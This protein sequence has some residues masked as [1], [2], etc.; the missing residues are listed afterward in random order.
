MAKRFSCGVLGLT[1]WAAIAGGAAGQVVPGE[2][3]A[4]G[5]PAAAAP[6]PPAA[7]G[8]PVGL[9]QFSAFNGGGALL[10]RENGTYLHYGSGYKYTGQW[11]N[12]EAG[13]FA[14]RGADGGKDEWS[15]TLGP[16]GKTL[17]I[18]RASTGLTRRADRAAGDG[19]RLVQAEKTDPGFFLGVWRLTAQ[20]SLRTP[21][22]SLSVEKGGAATYTDAGGQVQAGRWAAADKFDGVVV[23]A[24]GTT[25]EVRQYWAD[26]TAVSVY[27]GR[28]WVTGDRSK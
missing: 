9:W 22:G 6:V 18:K 7:A 2:G 11:G 15:V 25:F 14:F 21:S 19:A 26:N 24:G 23:T 3:P 8:S 12:G 20:D 4:A 27:N 28:A 10:V 16:E 1:M 5:A 13:A 17:M